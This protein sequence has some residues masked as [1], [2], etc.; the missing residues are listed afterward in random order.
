[1]V[2]ACAKEGIT[3][4]SQSEQTPFLTEPLLSD[5]GYLGDSPATQQ[6]LEGIYHIPPNTDPY[7]RK[8]IACL[9]RSPL[10]PCISK[11]ISTQDH[12]Q[13]WNKA[14]PN[15]AS[16]PGGPL[17]SD[18]IAG[19]KDNEIAAFDAATA[20]L[21]LYDGFVNSNWTSATECIIHK[22]ANVPAVEKMRIICLFDA[23]FNMINK[24]IGRRLVQ[25]GEANDMLPVGSLWV[26]EEKKSKRMRI[27]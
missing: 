19:T 10:L 16:H 1:M 12:I 6:V 4:F 13:A 8:L 27:E 18:I 25:L 3:R 20:N 7:A 15:T 23:S 17:Y 14:R 2:Q 9:R 21:P 24:I 22:K 5:F 26:Q 11:S